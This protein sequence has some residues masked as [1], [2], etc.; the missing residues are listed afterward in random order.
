MSVESVNTKLDD[1]FSN[2]KAE[3]LSIRGPWGVGKTH[4]WKNYVCT[5]KTKLGCQKYSYVSLFGLNSL[6]DVKRTLFEQSISLKQIGTPEELNSIQ[7]NYQQLFK[8]GKKHASSISKPFLDSLLKGL[9]SSVSTAYDSIAYSS[10]K[11]SVICFDDIERFSKSISLRDFLGLVSELKEAK[12][13]KIILLLN[14]DSPDLAEYVKYKEKVVDTEVKYE[15]TP[16]ECFDVAFPKHTSSYVHLKKRCT[17]L[18]IN[19]IRILTR[20]KAK[21]DEIIQL[22]PKYDES[23]KRQIFDNLAFLDWCNLSHPLTPDLIPPLKFVASKL[24]EDEVKEL[25][26]ECG[27][28]ADQHGVVQKFWDRLVRESGIDRDPEL[29]ELLA[30]YIE[31][32]FLNIDLFIKYCETKQASESLKIKNDRFRKAIDSFSYSFYEDEEPIIDELVASLEDVIESIPIK[33]FDDNIYIIKQ[34]NYDEY[35][36]LMDLF[37]ESNKHLTSSLSALKIYDSKYLSDSIFTRRLVEYI[38]SRQ[39]APTQDSLESIIKKNV[40]NGKRNEELL[41]ALQATSVDEVW[42]V[43]RSFKSHDEVCTVENQIRSCLD[44]TV[45]DQETRNKC[46][47]AIDMIAN[48]S[49][50]RRIQLI[51]MRL[52]SEKSIQTHDHD[53][54]PSL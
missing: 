16:T 51:K 11:N 35:Q 42:R 21:V 2:D 34:L 39:P 30:N 36:R 10:I 53:L 38:K 13:C 50:F 31:K 28:D 26:G 40:K 24:D 6:D 46:F 8:E 47:D 43:F 23:V 45:E 48:E 19:N 4:M 29:N 49:D 32:G 41:R 5:L 18:G 1:F 12:N 22:T 44:A 17:K 27:I 52:L 9:G 33:S 7:R 15:P 20:L 14:E 54:Q 37:F 25:M 3:V